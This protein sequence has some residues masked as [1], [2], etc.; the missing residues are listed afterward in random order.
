MRSSPRFK[1]QVNWQRH[2]AV[3]FSLAVAGVLA[4][5]AFVSPGLRYSIDDHAL[6]RSVRN[7]LHAVFSNDPRFANLAVST[8]RRKSFE[9]TISGSVNNASDLSLL[10]THIQREC[11]LVSHCWLKWDV[12]DRNAQVDYRGSDS[13]LFKSDAPSATAKE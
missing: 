3:I 13:E 5:P 1:E 10:R 12:F 9:V 7:D 4:F 2:A 11:E 8:I 6:D